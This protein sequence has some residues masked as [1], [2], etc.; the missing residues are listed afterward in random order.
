MGHFHTFQTQKRLYNCKCLSLCLSVCH[1]NPSAS[2]KSSYRPSSLSTIEPIDHW[3]YHPSSL[4]T[5]KPIDHQAYWPSSLSTIEPI[6]QWAHWPLSP[7]TIKPLNHQAHRPLSLL[8]AGLLLRLLSLSACFFTCSNSS[9]YAKKS[10]FC[11]GG[12]T[13]SPE[14]NKILDISVL[15]YPIFVGMKGE[16]LFL[17]L[18]PKHLS[19]HVWKKC[20]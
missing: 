8:T 13:T 2:Q 19:V 18:W 12:G 14:N 10:I 6:D 3:A 17:C 7:S 4:S 16:I 11:G 5:I 1:R 9:K 15:Y 20:L